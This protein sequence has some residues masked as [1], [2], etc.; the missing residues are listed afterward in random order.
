MTL[1]PSLFF[2]ALF[3]ELYVLYT[4]VCFMLLYTVAVLLGK[5]SVMDQHVT[6]QELCTLNML[7]WL[8]TF[9]FVGLFTITF[10]TF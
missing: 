1:V 6:K 5:N 4:T 8:Y 7:K 2:A 3:W 9:V 10:L